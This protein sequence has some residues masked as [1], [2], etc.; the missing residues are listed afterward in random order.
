MTDK[1]ESVK[2]LAS[3]FELFGSLQA[4]PETAVGEF[5][6]PLH[7]ASQ[8]RRK[9]LEVQEAKPMENDVKSQPVEPVSEC[10]TA[11]T[12]YQFKDIPKKP[13]KPLPPLPSRKRIESDPSLVDLNTS[14]GSSPSQGSLESGE[15]QQGQGRICRN[16]DE[17]EQLGN[18]D[19]DGNSDWDS[20]WES[21]FGSSSDDE[22]QRSPQ[23]EEEPSP[24]VDQGMVRNIHAGFSRAAFKF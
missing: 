19:S 8:A 2:D 9:K 6:N 11:K 1:R 23:A 16:V 10:Q 14:P 22:G 24:A 20:E 4:T 3:Q 13:D 18:D 5:F 21:D 7:R 12:M 15:H 17:D